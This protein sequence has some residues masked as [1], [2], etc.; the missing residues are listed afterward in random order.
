VFIKELQL[1][2]AY[3]LIQRKQF[4]I[5]NKKYYLKKKLTIFFVDRLGSWINDCPLLVPAGTSP[6]VAYL[7]DSIIVYK[8]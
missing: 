7:R 8:K 3:G 2:T 1:Y 6:V 5:N 4:Y